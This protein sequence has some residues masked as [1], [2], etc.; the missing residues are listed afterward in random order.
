MAQRLPSFQDMRR[1]AY[2]CLGDAQDHLRSD[3]REGAGP[4]AEQAQALMRARN[5]IAEAKQ[6]L[7]E[8]AH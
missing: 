3:W 5:A 1:D 6:A 7:N 4:T 2:R 8:A